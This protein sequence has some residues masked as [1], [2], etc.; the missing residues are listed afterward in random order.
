LHDLT[1][2]SRRLDRT[3]VA[4]LV[5]LLG[6][7]SGTLPPRAPQEAAANVARDAP[8]PCPAGQLPP[9]RVWR[10]TH[11]QLRN[12]LVDVFGFA[13]PAVDA[14]P[15]DSRLEGFANGAD[16]LGVPPLLLEYYQKAADEVS[17]DVVRRSGELVPCPLEQ[18]GTGACLDRFLTGV[19]LRAWR[20]PLRPEETARL[21]AVYEAGAQAGGGAVGLKMLVE[22]LIVSPHFLFRSELGDDGPGPV[23]RLTDWEL[24][25]ALSYALWDEP[26]DPPLMQVAA[27]GRLRDPA[28][29]HA[30]A[31]RLL[32]TKERASP[33]LNAFIRQWLRIDGLAT[34]GKD[35][36][37]FPS[38]DGKVAR[39]LLDENRL[40][41]DSVVFDPAGDGSLRTLLTAGY[42]FLNGKTGKIYGIK[43]KGGELA[44]TDL[45]PAQRRGLFTEAAFLAAHADADVTRPVD[46]GKFVRE[47]VLCGE[48]PPPPDNFKFDPSKIT[49]DMTGREKLTAHAKN[50]F[51][52][53]CH[54]LFDGIGFALE[55]YDAV[56]QWR[57]TDKGKPI[58]STGKLP[59][60]D[61]TELQF[62]NFVQ[63]VDELAARP[64]PYACFATHYLGYAT[65]RHADQLPA[66]EQAPVLA[67]FARSG[68][69][70]DALVLAVIDAP[71]FSLRRR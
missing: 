6:A 15:P 33:A 21:R 35:P 32:G 17:T 5:V 56:G 13:G 29:L 63:L 61:G 41:V 66:C 49:D 44:R 71:S 9:A 69:R 3:T 28:T 2:A 57:D 8:L 59:L 60:P 25:S 1:P 43:K 45:D 26:P 47:D 27:T 24:A 62:A 42:G 46:R 16:R 55:S 30:Q 70:L 20:R 31:V 53:R 23:T 39:D 58:D 14:L 68:Y 36:Q 67:S 40:L 19:G 38:Y 51:C 10:L 37:L 54:A 34:A 12:T 4:T 50:P 52:A 22:A 48:V 65:G 18:L 11:A 64:E 7:C